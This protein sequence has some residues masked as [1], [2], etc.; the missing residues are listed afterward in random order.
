[1]DWLLTVLGA[2]AIIFGLASLGWMDRV[3]DWRIRKGWLTEARRADWADTMKVW[4]GLTAL[5][6]LLALLG[7][8]GWV[9]WGGN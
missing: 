4:A 5:A 1:V 9:R 8:L 7:G 2:L 3:V 6:G